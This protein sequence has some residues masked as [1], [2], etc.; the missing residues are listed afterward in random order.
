M[1]DVRLRWWLVALALGVTAWTAIAVPARATYGGRTT[2]DEPQYLLSAISLGEDLDL[3]ISDE[4]RDER[5]RDFH[6]A[7]LPVQTEP[8]ADGRAISPH[9]PL[10][11]ALLAVPVLLG[12]WAGAKLALAA[13]AGLLAAATAWVAVRRFGV[14]PGAALGVAAAFGVASP[15]VAYSVQVYPELPAALAVTVAVAALTGPFGRRGAA[16]FVLAVVAL[17]W[18]AVKYVPVA[19]VLVALALLHLWREDRRHQAGVLTGG[20]ALAGLALTVF[21]RVVYGGWTV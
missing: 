10:L 12:G 7:E 17:P 1:S 5:W 15:L 14:A 20:L 19:G 11:P 18:L 2:A 8:N 4:L 21:H 13:L 16:V 6:T 9:D 3:D